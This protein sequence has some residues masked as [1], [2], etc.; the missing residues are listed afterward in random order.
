MLNKPGHPADAF[1]ESLID[2]PLTLTPAKKREAIAKVIMHYAR[3]VDINNKAYN[4]TATAGPAQDWILGDIVHS[5]PLALNYGNIYDGGAQSGIN[6]PYVSII[7]G[8]NDGMIHFLQNT[9]AK[10][11]ESGVEKYAFLPRELFSILPVLAQNNG[12]YNNP[13]SNNVHPYGMDGQVTSLVFDDTNNPDNRPNIIDSDI[14][15]VHDFAYIYAGMRRGGHSYYALDVTDPMHAPKYLGKI[16]KQTAGF[17]ELGLTF[18][19]VVPV[20]INYDDNVTPALVFAGGYD[21]HKDDFKNYDVNGKLKDPNN[22][23]RTDD[24]GMFDNTHGLTPDSEGNAIYIV[25]ALTLQLIW[26]STN[27]PTIGNT[28]QHYYQADLDYAIPSTVKPV[29]SDGDGFMDRIYVGDVAGN[30]WRGDFPACASPCT[31]ANYRKDNW[32]LTKLASVANATAAG[33]QRFFQPPSVVFTYD[34]KGPYDAVVIGSGDR[35]NPLEKTDQNRIYMIKDRNTHSGEPPVTPLGLSDLADVSNCIIGSESGCDVA[36][37]SGSVKNGWYI[38]LDINSVPAGTSVEGEKLFSQAIIVDG[39]IY[40]TSYVPDLKMASASELSGVSE[41]ARGVS[42]LY[43]MN[44]KD[45]T[46]ANDNTTRQTELAPGIVG[47]VTTVGQTIVLPG[48]VPID[49]L[50][51]DEGKRQ[52]MDSMGYDSSVSI[53]PRVSSFPGG[54]AGA[55]YIYWRENDIND[56]K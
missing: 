35:E 12:S 37:S 17:S 46:A 53:S 19:N 7:F 24:T 41:L 26:K 40:I 45:G 3:G 20:L 2:L 28:N 34:E 25:N 47:D 9:D 54:G 32:T 33:D 21:I 8:A 15:G 50:M 49:F 13:N 36:L 52:W 51:S 16:T 30:I 38:N 4:Y 56:I 14:S 44:L 42:Y 29:D 31:D 1:F 6:N 18:S 43:I 11:N 22:P 27:D 48:V 10:G 39:K 23:G 55:D 5:K